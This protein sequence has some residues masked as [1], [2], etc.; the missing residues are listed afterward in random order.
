MSEFKDVFVSEAREHL[1]ELNNYLV[2]FER[3][4]RDIETLKKIFRSVHT[5][6]G[7]GNTM[8]FTK[9]SELAHSIENLLANIRDSKIKVTTSIVDALL[10]GFDALE[11]EVEMI[12]KEGNDDE[13]DTS[14]IIKKLSSYDP[15]SAN[16]NEDHR[17]EEHIKLDEMDWDRINRATAQKKNVFRVVGGFDPKC[18]IKFAKALLLLRKLS[19]DSEIV[20]SNPSDED[21]KTGKIGYGVEFL[22]ITDKARGDIEKILKMMTGFDHIEVLGLDTKYSKEKLSKI[23]YEGKE[24]AKSEI[25]EKSRLEA[26]RQVQSV[27]VDIEKLDY[28]MNLVGELHIQNIRMLE[29]ARKLDSKEL[30]G[31][32][33]RLNELISNIQEEVLSQRMIPIGAIFNRFPRMI[34]DLSKKEDKKIELKIEGADIE[35]DR[36]IL[37]EIGDPLVHILRNSIDHGIER[38]DE[39]QK[40]GKP[41]YGIIRLKAFRRHDSAV[42]EIS[43]DGAGINPGS[44]KETAVKR[45]IISQEEADA[46]KEEK[47]FKLVFLPGFST[48]KVVTDISGRGVGMDVVMNVVKRLGGS[49]KMSSKPGKRT[50]IRIKLPLTLA[51]VGALLVEVGKGTYAIQL[52]HVDKVIQVRKSQIKTIQGNPSFIYQGKDIPM[53]ELAK[54]LKLAYNEPGDTITTVVVENDDSKVGFIVDSVISKQQILI[55][56]LDDMLKKTRGIAG[57]MLLGSGDIG[58]VLDVKAFA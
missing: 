1:D 25:F 49:I 9:F 46:M 35:F 5:L 43:D 53:V 52:N 19:A 31:N 58:L 12:R 48:K 50:D 44:I 18:N 23:E 56:P 10:E 3:N 30:M 8:G 33:D 27:K 4:P 37:D 28:L 2:S 16:Y 26:T 24:R 22:I 14:R 32:V 47:L 21:I 42:I 36:T 29:L 40:L 7:N 34:R 55:K 39:R 11:D 57:A 54:E 15:T 38:P 45:G 20:K 51:I 6:K 17:I 13:F 41:E